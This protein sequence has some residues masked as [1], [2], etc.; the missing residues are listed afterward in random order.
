MSGRLL[1]TGGV[2]SRRSVNSCSKLPL[3]GRW[4]QPSAP[5]D[6]NAS[7]GGGSVRP[8]A[9][10]RAISAQSTASRASS[11]STHASRAPGSQASQGA[12][13]SSAASSSSRASGSAL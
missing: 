5:A 13:S 12:F 9:A 4:I 7:G 6:S 1:R 11:Q 10:A 3:R 2:Q 8:S